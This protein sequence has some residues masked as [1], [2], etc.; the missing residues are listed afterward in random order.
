MYLAA[1]SSNELKPGGELQM[2]YSVCERLR[3]TGC[4]RPGGFNDAIPTTTMSVCLDCTTVVNV[5]KT[6]GDEQC[7][8]RA[9]RAVVGIAHQNSLVRC[10]ADAISEIFLSDY[11]P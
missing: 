11:S 10:R 6:H 1:Y 2:L 9:K 3:R 7:A 4:G 8:S 5:K